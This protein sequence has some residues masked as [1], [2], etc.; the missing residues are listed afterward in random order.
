MGHLCFVI[1]S[2]LAFRHSSFPGILDWRKQPPV[3]PPDSTQNAET[4]YDW[5]CQGVAHL[6]QKDP[7]MNK[8]L[9]FLFGAAMMAAV[10]TQASPPVTDLMARIHF[11][12]AEQISAIPMPLRS[13]I[14]GVHPSAGAPRANAEQL[15]RAP[16]TWLQAKIAAGTNDEAGQLRPLL[17]DLLGAEWFLQSATRRT[18]RRNWRWRSAGCR[19]RPALADHLE[20]V[21]EAWT[22][23]S[24]EK[25]RTA[26]S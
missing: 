20:G 22:G 4:E 12:G 3:S 26:G 6:A 19:P 9:T 13:P 2:S 15:S 14:F 24:V 17:D 23:M 18:G 7:S 5:I 25:I 1:L 16:Y 21:L 8:F 11:A 10:V